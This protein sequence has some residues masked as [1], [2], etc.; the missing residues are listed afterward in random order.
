MIARRCTPTSQGPP[1]D[2]GAQLRKAACRRQRGSACPS[3]RKSS[4]LLARRREQSCAEVTPRC[5]IQH[6]SCNPPVRETVLGFQD[7]WKVRST[8]DETR[9]CNSRSGRI[10]T[11]VV[12]RPEAVIGWKREKEHMFLE[13]AVISRVALLALLWK[14]FAFASGAVALLSVLGVN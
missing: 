6:H 3:N 1:S 7:P 10:S 5:N 14:R 9:C 8:R 4:T 12:R 11:S 13:A 2:Q